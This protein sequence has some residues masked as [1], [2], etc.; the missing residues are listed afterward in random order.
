LEVGAKSGKHYRL[1]VIWKIPSVRFLDYQH[2]KLAEREKA[3]ELFGTPEEPSPLAAKVSRPSRNNAVRNGGPNSREQI[4]GIK[5]NTFDLDDPSASSA[6]DKP[7]RTKLTDAERKKL[8]DKIR[9]AKSLD[10]I[11]RLEKELRDGS[12]IQSL[13]GDAMEE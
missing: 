13:G 6:N 8:E 7:I 3:E 9:N 5:S 11:A 12:I 1:W 2:V 10:E 4:M